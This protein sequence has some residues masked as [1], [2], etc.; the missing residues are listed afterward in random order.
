MSVNDNSKMFLACGV[1]LACVAGFGVFTA[2]DKTEN[3]VP[4]VVATTNIEPRT[5]ITDAM[6]KV[7]Q[8]PALGRN[9]AMLEDPSLVVG[10]YATGKIYAGQSFIQPMVSKQFDETGNSGFALAIPD[11]NLRAVSFQTDNTHIAGG[12]ISKGDFVDIIATLKKEDMETKSSITKTLLQGVEVFD[13]SREGNNITSVTLLMT[14]DQIEIIKHAYAV[15]DITY[16]LNPGNAKNSRTTGIIN[17]SLCDRY[18]FACG[19]PTK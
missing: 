1:G 7:E 16:A 13:V 6:V 9:E 2:L 4:V 12:K 17:K 3:L 14:L 10:G 5:Q 8:I 15:G 18:N 19:V 11:E